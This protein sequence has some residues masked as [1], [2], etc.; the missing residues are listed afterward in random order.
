MDKSTIF[1]SLLEK[2]SLIIVL[3]I[4]ITRIRLFKNIFQKEKYKLLDLI[5]ISLIFSGLQY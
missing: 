1:I 4:I 2:S 3:F 5:I